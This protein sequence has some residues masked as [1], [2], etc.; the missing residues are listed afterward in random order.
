[1]R[2]F[3]LVSSSSKEKDFSMRVKSCFPSTS[4]EDFFSLGINS[5]DLHTGGPRAHPLG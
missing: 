1:M 3:A 5:H 4:R 2:R